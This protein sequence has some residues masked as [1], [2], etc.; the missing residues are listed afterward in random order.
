MAVDPVL[1]LGASS[2]PP[3]HSGLAV[4][5]RLLPQSPVTNRTS[6]CSFE[7]DPNLVSV[8][9]KRREFENKETKRSRESVTVPNLAVRARNPMLFSFP[10]SLRAGG[11]NWDITE[12]DLFCQQF[13]PNTMIFSLLSE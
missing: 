8:V 11:V 13:F 3:C 4:K 6:R 9:Q 12:S 2:D 10:L 7:G 5:R 1:A